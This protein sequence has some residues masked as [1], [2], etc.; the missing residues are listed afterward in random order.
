MF[1]SLPDFIMGVVYMFIF[2]WLTLM[3]FEYFHN[4]VSPFDPGSLIGIGLVGCI[5]L[6]GFVL[7]HWDGTTCVALCL[8]GGCIGSGM[9]RFN[10]YPSDH[11]RRYTAIGSGQKALQ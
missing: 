11:Q 6:I 7:R 10:E 1:Q 5:G 3:A 2:A 8:L 4:R 9:Y